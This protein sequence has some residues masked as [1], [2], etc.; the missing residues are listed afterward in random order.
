MLVKNDVRSITS[1][2]DELK[3]FWAPRNAKM[4]VWY[5]LVQMIDE[6]KTEKMESFVGN[7]PR[8]MFNL[9]LHMLDVSIPHRLSN[10]DLLGMDAAVASAEVTKF[11]DTAW[12]DVETTFRH[13]GPRQSFKRSLIGLLLATGW[14]AVWAVVGDKGD[15]AYVALWN[16]AQVFPMWDLELGLSE[17]A[18][19]YPVTDRRAKAMQKS[20]GWIDLGVLHGD[21]IV[22]DYWWG[23]TK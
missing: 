12:H 15:K 4:Q 23:E 19:T 14:Y 9:V 5:R 8:S 3:N 2:C 10:P 18:H 20:L 21:Q 1:R 11:F 16:P 6:L 17:V 13:S 22:Q 7:D